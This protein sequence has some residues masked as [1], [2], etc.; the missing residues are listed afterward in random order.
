MGE[1]YR[2]HDTVL[3]RDVAI[4]VLPKSLADDA[5]RLA[6]FRREAEALA[7]LNHP[8]IAQM[9]IGTISGLLATEPP[10]SAAQSTLRRRSGARDRPSARARLERV[11]RY[12]LRPPVAQER[13]RWTRSGQVLL[14]LRH[15]WADG[16]THLAF[17]P[18]DLLARLASVTP[19]PRINLVLYYGVLGARAAWRRRIVTPVA[20]ASRAEAAAPLATVNACWAALMQRSFGFDVL[21]CPRCG[22]RLRLIALIQNAIVIERILRHL[23]LPAEL[24][25][26][27]PARP[28]PGLAAPDSVDDLVAP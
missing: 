24:P 9:S 11:C 20:A 16:T 15:R 25:A 6:R 28:P 5:E 2:A 4:K 7:A 3:N 13:L 21:A 17:D 22:G 10:S 19:K 18:L 27:R 26:M 12:A 1:V 8:N 23:G 14:E